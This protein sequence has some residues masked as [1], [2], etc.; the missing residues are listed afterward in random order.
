MSV[1]GLVLDFVN[2]NQTRYV[3]Q[4]ASIL[5]IAGATLYIV[6]SMGHIYMGTVGTPGAYEAMRHGTVDEEW[7]RA[8][9]EIW[10]DDVKHGRA[11]G[12][13]RPEAPPPGTRPGPA[14]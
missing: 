1:T 11:P 2:F 5:H 8:H 9:H 10:Y 14:H 7:A 3:L 13:P 4:V 6:A 12:A